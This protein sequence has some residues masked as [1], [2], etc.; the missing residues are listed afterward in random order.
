MNSKTKAMRAL[1]MFELG[2]LPK[3]NITLTGDFGAVGVRE[4]LNEVIDDA[5]TNLVMAASDRIM[6]IDANAKVDMEMLM[7]KS[8]GRQDG[9]FAQKQREIRNEK[10][11][12][13]RYKQAQRDSRLYAKAIDNPGKRVKVQRGLYVYSANGKEVYWIN[14]N[15]KVPVNDCMAWNTGYADCGISGFTLGDVIAQINRQ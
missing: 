10:S 2:D 9:L 7:T 8:D 5:I 14:R 11:S 4:Y 6:A 13:S 1:S 15:R 3:I 12:P